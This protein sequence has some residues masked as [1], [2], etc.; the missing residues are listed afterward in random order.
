LERFRPEWRRDPALGGGRHRS[1]LRPW[2]TKFNAK[3]ID[4]GWLPVVEQIY[5]WHY[6]NERYLRN[7]DSLARV[8]IVYSQQ[9]AAFYGERLPTPNRDPALGFYQSLIEARI[10]FEMI[11]DHLLDAEHLP[12]FRSLIV[13]NSKA[14][15]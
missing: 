3:S 14:T 5:S 2:F 15:S 12:P 1:S 6:A 9:S 11:H 10:R 8:A 13:S 7:L 4:T